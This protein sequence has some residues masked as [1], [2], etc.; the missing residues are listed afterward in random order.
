LEVSSS[1]YGTITVVITGL[2][3]AALVLLSARRIYRRV[4]AARAASA[5]V[6]NDASEVTPERSSTS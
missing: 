6:P 4:R 2:A 1:A 3:G 5:Q